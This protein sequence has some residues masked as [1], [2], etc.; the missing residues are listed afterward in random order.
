MKGSLL[1]TTNPKTKEE[2]ILPRF[3]IGIR[4]K[5]VGILF[6]RR[7][8]PVAP[9]FS[10]TANKTQGQTI[11]S[12]LAIYLWDDWFSHGQLY[13][14]SSRATH[15][16][17]LRYCIKNTG[18][19]AEGFERKQFTFWRNINHP[20]RGLQTNTVNYNKITPAGSNTSEY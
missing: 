5:K 4:Y 16:S 13:M 17:R 15:P 1:Y 2:V 18:W 3:W 11:T 8:F 10:I 19:K 12:K 9:A 20:V 6:K 14:V 7:Q